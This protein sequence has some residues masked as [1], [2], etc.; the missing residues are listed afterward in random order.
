MALSSYAVVKGDFDRFTRDPQD[1]FGRFLHGHV[2]VRAPKEDGAIALFDCA[3]D[4]NTPS[5][6]IDYFHAP[7]LD[8]ARF[9]VVPNL[10]DGR[11]LLPTG[12]DAN[13][14]TG[15][16]LDFI[17]NPLLSLP[18]G[19]APLVTGLVNL[20]TGRNNQ[21]W[22]RNNGEAALNVLEPMM[23]ASKIDKVY[24][25]GARFEREPPLG[26][27]DIHYNQ[28]DPPGPFQ[29]LDQIWQDGGVIV[30]HKDRRYEGF[31]VRFGTQSMRTDD[32]GL[33]LP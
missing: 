31:F 26:M 5:G 28:G 12:H 23:E 22:V 13:A 18:L 8:A 20:I 7:S 16:A 24:V 1:A 17:R 19:S 3:C 33:P 30:R 27:H 10:P 29:H 6:S 21:V 9:L 14:A 15:G 4:V 2:F 25:F 11:H 32:N